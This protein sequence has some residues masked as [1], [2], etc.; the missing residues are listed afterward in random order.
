[1]LGHILKVSRVMK[2]VWTGE[3]ISIFLDLSK[4]FDTLD[5]VILLQKLNYYD[6]KSV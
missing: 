1:M 2:G 6:I 3:N 4:A 5:H